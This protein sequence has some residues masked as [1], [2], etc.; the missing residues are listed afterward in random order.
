MG[1]KNNITDL[2]LIGHYTHDLLINSKDNTSVQRLG[3]G[4][5][6]ASVVAEGLKQKFKVV[7][8]VGDDFRYISQSQHS[9]TILA[10][11]QTT[12]FINYTSEF[13]RRHEVDS[14]C[15]P[16]YPK[17]IQESMRVSL[18]CGV[19]GEVL[20]QT[21]QKLR[22]K[23]ALLIGDVQGFIR[24][25]DTSNEVKHIHLDETVYK[26]V[27]FL[28]DYLKISDEELPFVNI[29]ELRKNI[30][31]LITYGDDGCIVLEKNNEFKVPG[32]AV[33]A[34]DSTGAGDSF[35]T[36]FSIG[37]IQDLSVKQSVYLGCCCGRIAVQ[38][39]GPPMVNSFR[40]DKYFC[41]KSCGQCIL[42]NLSHR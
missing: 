29:S 28:F 8:K 38:S 27:I 33:T 36:G 5:T 10:H 14:V 4:V 3:G 32:C 16:I 25:I 6:Y 21:I 20:P 12:S 15:K 13:P 23:S 42:K 35:L 26:E 11:T 22:E 24:Q 39:V 9:P 40:E 2:L 18:V 30:T 31:L 19:I 37:M 17:D 34:V 41:V 7:S 1:S